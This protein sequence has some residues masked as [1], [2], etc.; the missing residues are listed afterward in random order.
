MIKAIE[1]APS[2]EVEGKLI[3]LILNSACN[4]NTLLKRLTIGNIMKLNWN[5]LARKIAAI[6]ESD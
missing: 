1:N 4:K 5:L 2:H 3:L 6:V